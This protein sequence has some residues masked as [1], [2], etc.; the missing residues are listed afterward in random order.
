MGLLLI[1]AILLA[2]L[3][4]GLLLSLDQHRGLLT[5][6]GRRA[7]IVRLRLDGSMLS[8]R[9]VESKLSMKSVTADHSVV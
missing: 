1:Q 8:I 5:G 3:C 4:L 6:P 9:V 2:E 7:D